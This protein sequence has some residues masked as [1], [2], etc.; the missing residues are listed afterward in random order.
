MRPHRWAVVADLA[1]AVTIAPAAAMPRA[2]V[3]R[4][5]HATTRVVVV[6]LAVLAALAIAQPTKTVARVWAMQ[7]SAPSAKPWNTRSKRSR[8]WPPKPTAKP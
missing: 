3:R 6:P 4:V 8:N 7:L 1:S 2:P 5:A